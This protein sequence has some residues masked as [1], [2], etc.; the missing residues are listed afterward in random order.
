MIQLLGLAL[1]SRWEPIGVIGAGLGNLNPSL[2]GGSKVGQYIE[3][4][5]LVLAFIY[6]LMSVVHAISQIFKTKN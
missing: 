5:L 6:V 4:V 2:G 3:F 1:G